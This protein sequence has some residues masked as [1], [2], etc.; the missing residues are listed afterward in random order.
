MYLPPLLKA[1]GLADVT[2]LLKGYKMK[3]K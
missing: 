3:A 2:H 1:L